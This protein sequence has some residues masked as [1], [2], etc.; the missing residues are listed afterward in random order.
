MTEETSWQKYNASTDEVTQ[1][2]PSAGTHTLHQR[3]MEEQW[4]KGNDE[5]EKDHVLAFRP[6]P[7]DNKNA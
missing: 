1:D 3:P 6:G 4:V 7:C 5:G 2:A